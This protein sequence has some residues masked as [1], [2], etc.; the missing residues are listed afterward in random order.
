MAAVETD[1][2]QRIGQLVASGLPREEAEK[3]AADE[4]GDPI[5]GDRVLVDRDNQELSRS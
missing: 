4:A 1:R 5:V 2:E 3:I